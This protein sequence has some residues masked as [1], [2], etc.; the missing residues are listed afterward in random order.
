MPQTLTPEQIAAIGDPIVAG[1]L[2]GWGITW[3]VCAAEE[4]P[5]SGALAVCRPIEDA[6]PTRRLAQVYVLRD[7]PDGEDLA[8]TLRHELT[9]AWISPLVALIPDSDA[10][11]M[12]EEQLVEQMGK[13]LGTLGGRA[14]AAVARA[15]GDALGLLGALG[16]ESVAWQSAAMRMRARMSALAPAA[17]GGTKAM[18]SPE[19]VKAA[20]EA[21]KGGNGE[22][23]IEVLTQLLTEAASGGAE[24]PPESTPEPPAEMAGKDPAPPAPGAKPGASPPPPMEGRLAA[25]KGAPVSTE[26]NDAKRARLA[27]EE[28]EAIAADERTDAKERIVDRLRARLPGHTALPGI[29]KRILAA[30]SYDRAKEIAETAI[31]MGG[32]TPRARSGVEHRE[33]PAPAATGSTPSPYVVKDLVAEGLSEALAEEIVAQHA[34]PVHG[35]RLA[36]DTLGAARARLNPGASKFMPKTPVNGAP[37]GS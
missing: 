5:I 21:L 27:R 26:T 10:A 19:V 23:A 28:I 7:W 20:L 33:T 35:P 4:M 2:P 17:P 13:Y 32:G 15:A 16:V 14:R 3:I 9:H 29:E 6:T 30:T 34:I 31:E 24:M 25:R 8:E 12:L 18:M 22:A 36:A 37:R 1:L 11:V